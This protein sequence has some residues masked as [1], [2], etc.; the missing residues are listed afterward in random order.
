M[1]GKNPLGKLAE[2]AIG[3]VRDPWGTAGKV[4][5]QGRG[6]AAF[7]RMV[8][9]QVG[10][11]AVSTAVGVAGAAVGRATGKASEKRE[12]YAPTV[13]SPADLRPVP[14]VNEPAHP[15]APLADRSPEPSKR[16]GD[17]LKRTA[18]K[19]TAKK[20]TAKKATPA[21]VAEVVAKKAPAKKTAARKTTAK[22]T[23][24]K[25]T[26]PKTAR[27]VLDVEGEDVGH[28]PD[29]AETGLDQPDTEG[30]VDPSVAKAVASESETL[31]KAAEREPGV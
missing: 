3:S 14:E 11:T 8:V 29:T 12:T 6:T 17:P 10:G 31:R 15:T 21:D 24:A 23:T 20:T 30:I 27:Q 4:V 22:K 25:K 5:A 9:E 13:A 26:P 7:A 2:T 28:N 18:R 16:Q 1:A 19:A